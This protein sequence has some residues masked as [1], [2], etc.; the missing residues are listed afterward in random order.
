M[1]HP[2]DWKCLYET[3]LPFPPFNNTLCQCRSHPCC[4]IP[5]RSTADFSLFDLAGPVEE[6]PTLYRAGNT[7]TVALPAPTGQNYKPR[8]CKHP[9]PPPVLWRICVEY[10]GYA[11]MDSAAESQE[12]GRNSALAAEPQVGIIPG[13]LQGGIVFRGQERVEPSKRRQMHVFINTL[14]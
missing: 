7:H 11:F 8:Y 14:L 2:I 13:S 9:L 10:I 5:L 6:N 4:I 1:S 12:S 3:I